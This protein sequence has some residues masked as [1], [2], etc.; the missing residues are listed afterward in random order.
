MRAAILVLST[1]IFGSNFAAAQK[2]GY[3]DSDFILSKMPDYAN[4]RPEAIKALV[5]AGESAGFSHFSIPD[6]VVMPR[7]NDSTY[8][9]SQSGRFPGDGRGDQVHEQHAA[10]NIHIILERRR[11]A[12][13]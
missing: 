9:Y 13:G 10:T 8:P 1:F 12:A 11:R 4:A 6:H 7:T 3:I 2:F 5:D